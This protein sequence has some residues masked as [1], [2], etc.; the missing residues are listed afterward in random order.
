[1]G[2]GEEADDFTGETLLFKEIQQLFWTSD[3]TDI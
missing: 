2:V 3:L 1:M